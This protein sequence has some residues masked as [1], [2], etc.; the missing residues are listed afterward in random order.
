MQI[1]KHIKDEILCGN[2]PSDSKLPSIRNLCKDLKVSKNTIE[3][4]YE[5]S[6]AEGYVKSRIKLHPTL[7][8]W[9]TP[10]VDSLPVIF[11]GFAGIQIQHIPDDIEA[12]SKCW[13]CFS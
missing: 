7:V 2:I 13:F 6:I 4:A 3:A 8:N 12:L 11:I 1:Y 10:P 5:Q 9:I